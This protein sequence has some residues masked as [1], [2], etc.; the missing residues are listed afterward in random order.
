VRVF[1]AA[2]LSLMASGCAFGQAY[3][4]K[5]FA[6]SGVS[7]YTGDNGPAANAQ[8]NY[9][10]A[11]A[12]DSAGSLYIADTYNQCIRKV[13]NGVIVTVAGNGTPGYSG[14]NGP[15]TSAQLNY[16][17]GVA[18]DSAG[19]IYI[20]DYF[21]Q[22]IRKVSNGVIATVAGVGTWGFSGDNGPAANAQLY[23]PNG[24]AVDSAGNVYIADTFNYRVRKIS[25]GV[26][27]TVA[28]GGSVLGDGGPATSALLGLPYAVAVDSAGSL[29]IADAGANR[30]RKVSSGAI[31]TVAGNGTIGYSG[32]GG[33]ATSAQ[34]YD[35]F[36][37]AVDS[38]GNLYIADTGNARV[39]EVQ[40]GVIST[41]AGNGTP[42]YSGDG[43]PAGSAMLDYPSGVAVGPGIV[44]VSDADNQRIRA[45]IPPPPSFGGIVNSASYVGGKVAPGEIVAIFGSGMGPGTGAGPVRPGTALAGVQVLFDGVA[46]PLLYAQASQ[47][48]AI[49]PY[50]VAGKA[51]TQ[52]QVVYQG[53][54]S[55]TMAIPVVAAAPGIFTLS[56]SGSGAAVVL[57]QDGTLNAPG[58][59][60]ALGS[61]V[62]AYATGEGQTN[63]AGVDGQLDP[64]PPPQ[65]VQAV[66]ATIGGVSVTASASGITGAL[67][68]L[69]QIKLQVPATLAPGN[70]VLVLS[71]GGVASQAG[72]TLSV[73]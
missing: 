51:S 73:Q 14:D 25:N 27:T 24:V 70:A 72:V 16:P 41:V 69:L 6:G 18:V 46:A 31:T 62:T 30:I 60:A 12:V 68:G 52:V 67:A 38:T 37:V 26:I 34:L 54:S 19:N 1:T 11:V 40:N 3:T 61:V 65:P 66:T 9:P 8:L 15:A 33:P 56:E 2:V 44:Y 17:S 35:P 23:G 49:V 29:Y 32:D 71:I 59:Q 48:N 39:R 42:G 21:N 10:W 36:G 13:S 43:G 20:A 53:Q 7:G 63:P 50:E 28:G 58:N 47:V 57:N 55:N 45:L 64:S 5:T 22:R 4:I